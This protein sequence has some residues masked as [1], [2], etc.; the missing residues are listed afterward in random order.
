MVIKIS[1]NNKPS[2]T[3]NALKKLSSRRDK[4]HKSLKDFYG[5]LKHSFGNALDYQKKV[6]DEW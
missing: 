5:K 2:E 6:R 3:R 1:K 4:K